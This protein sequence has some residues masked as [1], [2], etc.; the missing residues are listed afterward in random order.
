VS[1]GAAVAH[2]T[3]RRQV[4]AWSLWDWGSAAFNAVIVS[5]VFSVYLT[6]SVGDDLPGGIS[7][8]SWLGWSLGIG[9]LAIAVLAPIT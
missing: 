3:E 7:A 4:L 2:R 6:D 8:S 5:F 1:E 9:G